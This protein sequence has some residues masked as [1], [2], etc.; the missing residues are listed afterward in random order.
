[1]FVVI[2]SKVMDDTEARALERALVGLVGQYDERHRFTAT[3]ICAMHKFWLG[4]I[5]E[6]AGEY[7]RLNIS[8]GEFPFA[9]AAQVPS[10][11]GAVRA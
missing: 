10:A 9:A 7:R 5:Y 11:H 4:E 1:M 8:K 6:W 3:D 2:S